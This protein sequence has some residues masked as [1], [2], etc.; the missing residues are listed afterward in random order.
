MPSMPLDPNLAYLF[1]TSG[2]AFIVLGVVALLLPTDHNRMAFT[3]HLWLVGIFGVLYG[4][5]DFLDWQ[6][7]F[8]ESDWLDWTLGMV[9]TAAF[10]SL[11]EFARRSL[12]SLTPGPMNAPWLSALLLLLTVFAAQQSQNPALGLAN[13]SRLFI[14]VPAALLASLAM[15]QTIRSLPRQPDAREMLPWLVGAAIA[16]LLYGLL[17]LLSMHQD[18]ALP[19]WLPDEREIYAL[20]GVPIQLP[21]AICALLA[22]IALIAITRISNAQYMMDLDRVLNIINGFVFRCRNDRNWSLLYLNGNVKEVTG[23]PIEQLL[24]S[25]HRGLADLIH[26][27]DRE[28]VWQEVQQSIRHD[29]GTYELWYQLV[30]Q[31][32]T[33]RSVQERGQAVFGEDGAL[34]YLQGHIMDATELVQ[35]R[36]R[37]E[38]AERQASLGHWEYDARGNHAYWSRE[39]FRLLKSDPGTGVPDT[40]SYLEL[41]HPEDRNAVRQA[42]QDMAQGNHPVGAVFRTNPTNGPARYLRPTWHLIHD[43]ADNHIRYAGTLQ[44]V[45]DMQ[46]SLQA[47]RESKR[48]QSELLALTRREQSRMA[49]LLSAMSIGILFEDHERRVEYVNPAFQ[50]MW[51]IDEHLNLTGHSTRKVLEHSP[52]QFARPDHASKHVLHVLDTQ[53]ISEHFELDLHDGRIFTQLSYPVNEED[54]RTIGRLWLY[55]DVTHERQTAQQLVYLA[56]HDPLTGLY[57]RHRFQRHLEWMIRSAH[58][59]QTRFAVLYFDLDDFKYINDSFGHRAGDTVLVRTAGEIATLVRSGEVFARLGGDEFAILTELSDATPNANRLA[60]RIS[61]TVSSIPFRFRGSNLRLTTSIGITTYPQH[62]DNAEDLV[63]HADAAMYQ[64]KNAGKNTWALYDADRDDSANMMIRMTW[65]SRI[66]QALERDLLELHFQGVYDTTSRELRHLEALVRMRDPADPEQLIMPGQFIPVAEKS[67]QI[68]EIDRWVLRNAIM[69]LADHPQLSALAVNISGRSFDQPSLARYIEQLLRESGIQPARL[70]IELTETAAVSEMQD[71]QRFI[72]AMQQIGCLVCL[73]DF[74]TGFST[75]AYLKYLAVQ[76][77]KIDGIF[78][79]DL[80]NH[81]DNQAFVKAMV[82][83]AHGLGKLTVAEFVEDEQT[84]DMLRTLGVDMAQ[85]YHMDRPGPSHPALEGRSRS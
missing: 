54:G 11:L 14:G 30:T 27:S 6:R 13:A 71:A 76:A 43:H 5:T 74:G 49:A 50:R 7:E 51:G 58:R 47:L 37:L 59:H 56:E 9:S 84:L 62:G 32:G 20:T 79:R 67:G 1:Y 85:G 26:S 25:E 66:A 61:R 81:A 19:A 23:Y 70:V 8:T 21:M 24:H 80:H 73:D 4:I 60:E 40:D 63:A 16:S 18:P 34:L 41:I 10:L 55:E 46:L 2:V 42:M 31:D 33:V 39:M 22:A 48:R 12:R 64:A 75:F 38:R 29:G 72:E 78:I 57:N 44:D 17:S 53:E 65:V 15:V 3:R 82:D 69:T 36:H 77:L 52:H 28:D 45:T 35:S 68:M 83:V